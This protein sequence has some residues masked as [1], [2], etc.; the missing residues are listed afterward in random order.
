MRLSKPGGKAAGIRWTGTAWGGNDVPDIAPALGPD[1][2][3][4]PFIIDSFK[5]KEAITMKKNPNYW[6]GAVLLDGLKFINFADAGGQKTYDALKGGSAQVAFLRDP[7]V[8]AKAK[9]DNRR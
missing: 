9:S 8:V 5:A 6:G 4:G 3:A 1:T 7:Q 2:G